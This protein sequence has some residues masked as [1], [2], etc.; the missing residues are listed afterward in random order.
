MRFLS[1]VIVMHIKKINKPLS[2]EKAKEWTEEIIPLLTINVPYMINRKLKIDS[3]IIPLR[4]LLL[5][6]KI[7]KK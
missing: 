3:I 6:S 4:N 5:C 1:T 2:G 7:I